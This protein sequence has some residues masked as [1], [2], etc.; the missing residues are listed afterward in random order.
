LNNVKDVRN[1]LGTHIDEAFIG[2]CTNGRFEDLR[3]AAENLK[4]MKRYTMM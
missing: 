4:R 2:S 3:M 1:V